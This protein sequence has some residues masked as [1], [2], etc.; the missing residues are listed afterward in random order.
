MLP[1]ALGGPRVVT[2]MRIKSPQKCATKELSEEKLR[3]KLFFDELLYVIEHAR[4]GSVPPSMRLADPLDEW[5]E[6]DK[7]NKSAEPD[8][9]DD[10]TKECQLNKALATAALEAI[11]AKLAELSS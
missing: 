10:F 4:S 11:K 5:D 6:E 3:E 8:L 2:A 1:F 7:D 9:D